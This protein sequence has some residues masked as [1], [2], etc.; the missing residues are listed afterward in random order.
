MSTATLTNSVLVAAGAAAAACLLGFLAALFTITLPSRAQKVIALLSAVAFALPPF[1]IINC[2]LDLLGAN[3]LIHRWIPLPIFSLGG[4]VFLLV[5]MLWPIAFLLCWSTWQSVQ[6]EQVESDFALR[7]LTLLRWVL[8]PAV[9]PAMWVAIAITFVLA[10]NN[11]AVPSILQVKVL[12]AEMWVAF[13][14]N[15]DS[16]AALQA[17]WPLLVIPLLLIATLLQGRR[18][19]WPRV[20]EA[21]APA[22]LRRQVGRPLLVIASV[23]ATATFVL[24]LAVPLVQ[25]ASAPRT[26][27]EFLPATVAGVNAIGNS[28]GYAGAAALLTGLLGVALWRYHL[29]AFLWFL[30]LV[31]GVL[32]GIGFI[33]ALNRPQFSWFYP[34]AGIVILALTLRYSAFVWACARVSLNRADQDLIDL[35]R[36]STSSRAAIF[37]HAQWPQAAVQIA[38]AVYLVYLLCLWD[39]ESL[40]MIV[41]PGG[42][43][44]AL[45]IFNLLHYGH[46]A[47]VNA[48]C[49]VLLLIAV[50]PLIVWHVSRSVLRWRA[51][52]I[53]A[54][55]CVALTVCG[56]SPE[57]SRGTHIDSSIFSHVE[58]IG[59][60]GTSPGQ[61]SKP[62]SVAVDSQDNVFVADM[63][64]RIQKFSPNGEYLLSWR[65]PET[66][67]GKAK[68][69][70]RDTNGNI[71]VLEPH[72][73]RVNHFTPEGKLV[74]QWGSRGTNAGELTLPRAVAVDTK[75]NV[76]LSEYTLVDRVQKFS[77]DGQRCLGSLGRPGL[78][79]SEFNRAEG[80]GTDLQDR[81]YVADSCNHRIQ[82]FGPDGRFL[83]TYGKPGRGVGELD[84]PYDIRVDGE[85]RQYVCEFGN[86]RIQIFDSSDRPFETIGGPGA[87][88][89]RF[90]NPWSIALDSHGNLYV[91]DSQNHRV[92]KLIR[93]NPLK[94]AQS[95]KT[96]RNPKALKREEHRGREQAKLIPAPV[97]LYLAFSVERFL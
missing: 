68:G 89:G 50:A 38:A 10:L 1:L 36:M 34:T 15:L 49:V 96:A 66:D 80:V 13:N 29:A 93:K 72:Y 83:R 95:T 56:C 11:F 5:L 44:L 31:P 73:Q 57:G 97:P 61:F 43:T 14:T 90:A 85:G 32:L 63:T 81:I 74:A 48:L 60:R 4:A 86:S 46:N 52:R 91:A 40:V 35:L 78:G 3:G 23:T 58:I 25:L 33:A 16:S 42:E 41:P 88:A 71:V 47:H 94:T 6:A 9:L 82:I 18:I 62:R 54:A 30:F 20:T 87:R 26:W 37:Q 12:P 28:L 19:P 21:A 59:S 2:W 70:D 75:G 65:M 92:Q 67:L 45:R 64:G 8:L 55:G 24:A 84:Y 39:V 76:I 22:A 51:A 7:G 79:P 77:P 17:S 69:M 53:A 27:S